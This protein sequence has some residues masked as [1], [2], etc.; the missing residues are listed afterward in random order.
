MFDVNN[1]KNCRSYEDSVINHFSEDPELGEIML[2]DAIKDGDIIEIRQ[3]WHRI[4]EAKRRTQTS[5]IENLE[6]VSA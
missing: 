3:I 6:A 1:L 5:K 4:Q 2:N